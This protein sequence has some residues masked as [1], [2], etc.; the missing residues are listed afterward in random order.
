MVSHPIGAQGTYK[1]WQMH[2]FITFTNTH[3]YSTCMY[4]IYIIICIRMLCTHTNSW[5]HAHTCMC[6][7]PLP[8][9]HT[10]TDIHPHRCMRALCDYLHPVLHSICWGNAWMSFIFQG[11]RNRFFYFSEKKCTCVTVLQP[12][13]LP[14]FVF[15]SMEM[16]HR[17]RMWN[18]FKLTAFNSCSPL[19]LTPVSSHR[20]KF[21][22]SFPSVNVT[23][24]DSS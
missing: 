10:H 13:V 6:L 24:M 17:L 4:Y 1:G 14:L 23:F 22:N 15:W 5:V 9:P 19:F 11:W 12:E 18:N 2:P 3:A 20:N 21:L 7:H 8:V 16:Q